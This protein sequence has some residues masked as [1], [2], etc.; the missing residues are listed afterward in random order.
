[1]ARI[2]PIFSA[3]ERDRVL[4]RTM[5]AHPLE[6]FSVFRRGTPGLLRDLSYTFVWNVGFTALFYWMHALRRRVAALVAR[7]LETEE[8]S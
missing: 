4:R 5:S 8:T 2:D 3:E 7:R 6:M 1:M